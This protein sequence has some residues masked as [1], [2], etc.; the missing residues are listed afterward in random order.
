MVMAGE[1]EL[2][3]SLK[4]VPDYVDWQPVAREPLVALMPADHPHAHAASVGLHELRESPFIL[5]ESGFAL[6]RIIH[7][8]CQRAGFAPRVIQEAPQMASIVSLVAAGVGISVVP[9]AMRHMGAEG[10]EYRP[11]KGD[12]PHALLDMAYR[13]HDRSIAAV[14]AVDMLRRLA[15]P[16]RN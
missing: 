13:R 11:I 7:E 4:P 14:N 8:A 6:N 2:A 1:I 15:H 12:A 16:E 3:A 5:F 9:A 10:I